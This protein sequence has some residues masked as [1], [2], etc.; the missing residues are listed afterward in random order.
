M[1]LSLVACDKQKS[2]KPVVKIG[3][4]LPLTGGA[5]QMGTAAQNGAIMAVE[6]LNKNTQ[7]KYK[8]EFIAEN[9]GLAP[10]KTVSIYT[11]LIKIDNVAGIVSFNTATGKIIKPLADK[12]RVLH[13][14]SAA[15]SSIGDNKFNYVNSYSETTTKKWKM[16]DLWR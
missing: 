8:Y 7:N 14:S 6:Q 5:A 2:D 11:K 15:D 1:A 3:G 4:V 10:A 12:Y 9:M 16:V 13:I